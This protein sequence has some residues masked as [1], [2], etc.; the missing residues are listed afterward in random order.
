MSEGFVMTKEMRT[1]EAA[2]QLK[3]LKVGDTLTERHLKAIDFFLGDLLSAAR[4]VPIKTTTI[5]FD[6]GKPVISGPNELGIKVG[7]SDE[8]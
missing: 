7:F 6:N 8:P 4:E 5:K 3:D 1:F 2:M